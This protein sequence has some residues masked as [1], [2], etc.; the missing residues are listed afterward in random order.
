MSKHIPEK[1]ERAHLREGKL[2][3]ESEVRRARKLKEDIE[4]QFQ[5]LREYNKLT[6]ELSTIEQSLLIITGQ[7]E[8]ENPPE[9]SEERKKLE[10]QI[11]KFEKNKNIIEGRLDNI[12]DTA[13]AQRDLI[14]K[15]HKELFEGLQVSIDANGRVI[16]I[17]KSSKSKEE[18]ATL[19]FSILFDHD[20]G[21]VLY[22]GKE[23][24]LGAGLFGRVKIAQNIDTGEF[25]AIKIQDVSHNPQLAEDI[26]KENKILQDLGLLN[27]VVIREE[28]YEGP[29]S[30]TYKSRDEK[31]N[32]IE[33]TADVSRKIKIYTRQKLLSGKTLD[34]YIQKGALSPA[35]LLALA[36]ATM[37]NI[38]EFHEK[39]YLHRDI[40]L[41]NVIYDPS[42]NH[43]Q[44]IDFG[45]SVK[46]KDH[47]DQ[48]MGTV[49]YM[50]PEIRQ[51][52]END[53]E[54]KSYN[55]KTDIYAVGALLE[56]LFMNAHLPA[57]I[58]QQ[59]DV[60]VQRMKNENRHARPENLN[61]SIEQIGKIL[62]NLKKEKELP[63]KDA[64]E[65]T[66][67]GAEKRSLTLLKEYWEKIDKEHRQKQAATT[68]RKS[69]SHPKNS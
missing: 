62:N 22:R 39:G 57:A 15:Y 1:I 61:D 7:L 11:A 14:K 12:S 54:P 58:K 18:G 65:K 24:L 9:N 34:A 4:G 19:P 8:S 32:I 49:E 6:Q 38:Q 10:E 64:A 37:E 69:K 46:A 27:G 66:T 29:K 56:K 40:K 47:L 50:A 16:K 21:S 68:V 43:S 52:S 48:S 3:T 31:G 33:E 30:I 2:L 41:E 23:K 53:G 25:E 26:R 36:K 17:S 42:N 13:Q 45:F 60:I 44:L 51:K 59:L 5:T 35:N 28:E 55:V 63:L 67:P 20:S